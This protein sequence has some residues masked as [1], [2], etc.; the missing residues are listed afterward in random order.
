MA[1]RNRF[2]NTV[3]FLNT[4]EGRLTQYRHRK[5]RRLLFAFD[6]IEPQSKK[7]SEAHKDD[8]QRRIIQA[9]D[10]QRRA[11]FRGPLALNLQLSTTKATAPQ[12][13]TIAKNL[14]DLLA[15]RRPNVR[16]ARKQLLYKDDS[17]VHALTVSCTHGKNQPRISIGAKSLRAMLSDLEL[18]AEALRS[19]DQND[20]S[21]W[22]GGDRAQDEIRHFKQLVDREALNRSRVGDQLYN[23][24]IKFGRWQA[25]QALLKSGSITTAQLAWLFGLPNN[26]FMSPITDLWDEVIRDSPLRLQI[27][28]LPTKVGQS[29]AFIN[30]VDT[31]INEFKKKWDWIINPLVVPVAL[32]VIVR[33][34]PFT[35]KGVLHDLDNVVRD[36]LLPKIVPRFGTVTDYRWTI[37]FDEL[38]QR[39][40]KLADRW[41]PNP[42]PP[43]ATRSGVTRYEAWRLPPSKDKLPGFVS[44]AMVPDLGFSEDIFTQI[45]RQIAQWAESIESESSRW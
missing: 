28:E 44:V 6:D 29:G 45:D 34:G 4:D 42:T 14:L 35:P 9:L 41:G 1:K 31:S 13:H 12:A 24:M 5:R 23:A 10:A 20:S 11:D 36:Y 22:Y 27:G 17:Q 15:A 39:D 30:R 38:R 32:E 16:A 43:K 26:E 25:Q 18:A 40:R 19:L 8:F 33:P 3:D 21:R 2:L 7:M 37:D